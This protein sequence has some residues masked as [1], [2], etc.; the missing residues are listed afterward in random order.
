MRR[1][2]RITTIAALAAG[3]LALAAPIFADK[4]SPPA[5]VEAEALASRLAELEAAEKLLPSARK[6]A[7]GM[8][9]A[10][11]E[12]GA[13]AF[14][15]AGVMC[16]DIQARFA[17]PMIDKAD[18]YLRSSLA[19]RES[20]LARV[21]LGSAHIIQ[22]RDAASVIA[23]VAEANTGLKE[24][25]AAVKAAPDDMLVRAIRVECTIELPE[26]FKRLDTVTSDLM[27]LLE[28]YAKSPRSFEGVF[29]PSRVFE[30]KA[31]ELDLRGKPSLA[32]QYRARASELKGSAAPAAGGD[33]NRP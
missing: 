5:G 25:D 9:S 24:V 13:A 21:Y 12:R 14:L 2:F 4:G 26:M 31:E 32:A 1:I 29:P 3:A 22:A 16:H 30:L 20:A 17:R 23:K 7:E 15:K 27:I 8:G 11:R 28:R 33:G 18:Q 10:D 19:Y 6:P